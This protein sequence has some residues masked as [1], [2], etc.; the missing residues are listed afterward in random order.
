VVEGKSNFVVYAALASNAAIAVVKFVAAAFT[1]SSAMISEGIHST[2]DTIDQALLLYGRHRSKK[3][4]DQTHP[5]GHGSELYFW[6]LI[7]AVVIFAAGGGMA[8]IEGLYRYFHPEPLKDPTWNYCVLGIAAVFELISWFIGTR[9]FSRRMRPR[10]SYWQAYRRSKD[11]TVYTVVFED[12][13]A[14]VGLV[15][16][17]FGIFF[18]QHYRIHW[19]EALASVLIGAVL[20]IVAALL[21]FEAKGLLVGE[22]ADPAVVQSI[23]QIVRT[24]PA[25]EQAG[26]PLTMQLGPRD[27]LLNVDVRFRSDLSADALTAAVDRLEWSIR[28]KHPEIRQIFIEAEAFRS[29][30]N[31]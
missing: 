26:I 24:D 18:A 28:Q 8:I 23:E 19:P 14:I 2:V 10:E 4:P 1:A 20:V 17:F 21:T 3:P 7:V 31:G 13:A 15:I 22:S 9:E 6:A 27:V 5:F 25:I 29:D 30:Q 16:A 11:P 12:S